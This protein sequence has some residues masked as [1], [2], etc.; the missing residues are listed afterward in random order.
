MF[1]RARL[2]LPGKVIFRRNEPDDSVG[3]LGV[4]FPNPSGP[5][6]SWILEAYERDL[7]PSAVYSLT[8][9]R[10]DSNG[11]TEGS[12]M[13]I[14]GYDEDQITGPINWIHTSGSVHV[15]VPM[16]GIILNGATLKRQDGLPMQAIIDVTSR[17]DDTDLSP[18]PV[19]L[20]SAPPVSFKRSTKSWVGFPIQTDQDSGHSLAILLQPLASN[21]VGKI[22]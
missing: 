7:I 8:L 22:I 21:S 9:G 6:N 10:F 18:A 11:L 4:G 1:W 19:V 17:S 5:T 3:I 12:L 20:S 16:D 15:Q 14:G 13:I 2:H